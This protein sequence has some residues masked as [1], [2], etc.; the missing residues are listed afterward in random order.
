MAITGLLLISIFSALTV[1]LVTTRVTSLIELHR[2]PVAVKYSAATEVGQW[3]PKSS[4]QLQRLHLSDMQLQISC[5]ST[6][7]KDIDP[8]DW[9]VADDG[10]VLLNLSTL[11]QH[12]CGANDKVSLKLTSSLWSLYRASARR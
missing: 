1:R 12:G 3:Q 8:K 4:A 11:S 5:E 7:T 10:A 9:R 6:L 2:A